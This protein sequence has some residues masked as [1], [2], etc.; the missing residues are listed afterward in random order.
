[1]SQVKEC[2]EKSYE[3]YKNKIN[4]FLN[5]DNRMI[6]QHSKMLGYSPMY[7]KKRVDNSRCDPFV[8]IV[9]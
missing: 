1:M 6:L 7:K 4:I 3:V 2:L 8:I 5:N 9:P